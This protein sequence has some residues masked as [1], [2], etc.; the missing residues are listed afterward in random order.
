M[1]QLIKD[2]TNEVTQEI[3]IFKYALRHLLGEEGFNFAN[4]W[5]DTVMYQNQLEV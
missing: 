2:I 4:E 5:K 1:Q 3:E